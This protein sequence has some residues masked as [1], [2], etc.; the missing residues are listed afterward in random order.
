MKSLFKNV[1]LF[2]KALTGTSIKHN[3]GATKNYFIFK[4]H[5]DIFAINCLKFLNYD[6]I[7]RKKI[8]LDPY[9]KYV[10]NTINSNRQTIFKMPR[11]STKSTLSL[12]SAIHY[13]IFNDKSKVGIVCFNYSESKRLLDITKQ[14]CDDL[15]TNK[16][17]EDWVT[18]INS[19]SITFENGSKIK[20]CSSRRDSE[21]YRSFD[22]LILDEFAFFSST[23]VEDLSV[24]LSMFP[25]KKL[26]IFST[27]KK[28]SKFNE[29]FWNAM[30][31]IDGSE[32]IPINIHYRE[33]PERNR[34]WRE[35]TIR[36]SGYE[37][38]KEEYM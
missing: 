3:P 34:K 9:Q 8:E 1:K 31:D 38:F 19:N 2:I 27:Q 24:A 5:P 35:E 6:A 25:N 12:I 20:F 33:I 16:Y 17:F 15:N 32:M 18:E 30:N 13:A 37:C 10:L 14:F 23:V 29:L 36:L 7:K 21:D 26:A 11:Q 4:D 22:F 28:D